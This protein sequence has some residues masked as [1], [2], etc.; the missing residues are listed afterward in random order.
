MPGFSKRV[1]GGEV[2]DRI[3]KEFYRLGTGGTYSEVKDEAGMPVIKD[4]G[5]L[6][7]VNPD[8]SGYDL[9][10][11]TP[12]ARMWTAVA[13]SDYHPISY[14]AYKGEK[15]TI[16]SDGKAIFYPDDDKGKKMAILYSPATT[17]TMFFTVNN[18]DLE[19]YSQANSPLASVDGSEDSTGKIQHGKQLTNNPLMKP[20]AGI[21]SI[22]SKTQG[23]LGAIQNT[24]VN[25]TVHNRF[26]F[27]NIFLPYFLKPGSIVCV[28]L[29][30]S[31]PGFSL[32]DIQ[33]Q[34]DGEDINM[35]GFYNFLYNRYLVENY[36]RTNTL[37]GNVVNYD[38]S[39]TTDGSFECSIEIVSQNTALLDQGVGGDDDIQFLFT[40]T[41]NDVIASIYA[42]NR[43][44]TLSLK[45]IERNLRS[46]NPIDTSQIAKDFISSISDRD[47]YK[48]VGTLTSLAIQ[49]GI[50]HQD[51]GPNKKEP[52]IK[53]LDKKITRND[54]KKA[55]IGMFID[56]ATLQKEKIYI[57]YGLFEDVFLN[58]FATGV[59]RTKTKDSKTTSKFEQFPGNDFDHK[60]DS[61]GVYV[62]YDEYFID[63][64]TAPLISG[65]KLSDFLIPLNW[66][67]SYNSKT[68][69][70]A[71][72]SESEEYSDVKWSVSAKDCKDG[73][74]PNYPN[75]SVIPLRDVFVDVAIIS[76]AFK[77]ASSVNDAIVS[78][79]DVLNIESND[80]WNLKLAGA[81]DANTGVRIVD[82]NLIPE[83]KKDRLVFDVTGQS[84]IVSACNLKYSTPKDGLAS[85]LAI[86]GSPGPN[87]FNDMDLTQFAYFQ[88]L[89]KSDGEIPPRI[90]SLP[91]QG[92]TNELNSQQEA[93]TVDLTAALE[94]VIPIDVSVK[95]RDDIE[96]K[97]KQYQKNFDALSET[98]KAEV[99]EEGDKDFSQ[100][101]AYSRALKEVE[102]VDSYKDY[103]RKMLKSKYFDA[104]GTTTIAPILPIELSLTVYGNN[105]LQ[106]GDYFTVNYLPAF[107]RDK[108]F[109]Q[110][111][112]IEHSVDTNGWSTTYQ[113]VM[114]VHPTEK[115]RVSG[116]TT[117]L[118]FNDFSVN[119]NL[120]PLST[121]TSIGKLMQSG[122]R[123]QQI[124]EIV[125]KISV[126]RY[127]RPIRSQDVVDK[128]STTNLEF[129]IMRFEIDSP[130]SWKSS[131][132]KKVNRLNK[133]DGGRTLEINYN[134]FIKFHHSTYKLTEITDLNGLSYSF[135]VRDALF[136][137][138]TIID[139]QNVFINNL[140]G[141]FEIQEWKAYKFFEGLDDE[142]SIVIDLATPGDFTNIWGPDKGGVLGYTRQTKLFGLNALSYTEPM[143]RDEFLRLLGSKLRESVQEFDRSFYEVL[144]VN[145]SQLEKLNYTMDLEYDMSGNII[146]MPIRGIYFAL[147][148]KT[149]GRKGQGFTD[150][151]G[152]ELMDVVSLTNSNFD[153]FNY[154]PLPER[155]FK[156]GK[157]V[158]D[159]VKTVSER[160]THYKQIFDSGN[161][162]SRVGQGISRRDK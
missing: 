34:L 144:S 140:R 8:Y 19:S 97:F 77:S 21:T 7:E 22:S 92:D 94:N 39:L 124:V 71:K 103:Y 106:I 102:Y 78:I 119:K 67:E 23:A 64:Q 55:Q 17:K 80:V 44:L 157:N 1:F 150:D 130:E 62:R 107:Y 29:G 73:K 33:S 87:Y 36:G 13:V 15:I 159:F 160:Y 9:G 81:T 37:M 99:E 91:Y 14:N 30:W 113:T 79:L 100:T 58:N 155:L 108:V 158:F 127:P 65:E 5:V 145:Q 61:R 141:K 151:Y 28:D 114:R 134:K 24:T 146:P 135:A 139:Y 46:T 32:Y 131:V 86:G 42:R 43:G 101:D 26:D 35:R 16:N 72:W 41:I 152:F 128:I 133:E 3:I 96:S 76:A 116:R 51:M 52:V 115:S 117:E 85:I 148:T 18:H 49:E 75:V 60:F 149:E 54:R 40:N 50:F 59:I 122:A 95:A 4:G 104:E 147:S 6:Q 89:N 83:P 132:T 138:D 68:L 156:E 57:S 129:K 110:V 88:L 125:D 105:Y 153:V 137:K 161:E 154:I 136:G 12:F 143:T 48:S 162:V 45:H 38:S 82:V 63:I 66:D 123:R 70:E 142:I 74:H 27:E 109:F 69:T 53:T 126:R 93:N 98:L 25:F 47:E 84:S 118:S 11:K 112:G 2:S 31:Y 56:D 121:L 10:D 120:D 20:P 90:R 111:V